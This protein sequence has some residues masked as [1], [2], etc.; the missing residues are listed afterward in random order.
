MGHKDDVVVGHDELTHALAVVPK[1]F[2]LPLGEIDLEAPCQG[3]L[4]TPEYK[5]DH[6][7]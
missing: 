7:Q 4:I 6:L 5:S 2:A 3:H 1:K